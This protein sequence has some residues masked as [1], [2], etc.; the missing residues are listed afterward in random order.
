MIRQF[1]DR[2]R[3]IVITHNKKTMQAADQ[4]YGVTMQERGV[5]TRVKVRFDQVGAHGELPATQADDTAVEARPDRRKRTHASRQRAISAEITPGKDTPESEERVSLKAA[6]AS[7]R[8]QADAPA[9]DPT[10]ATQPTEAAA[11]PNDAD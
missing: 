3:F 5:S 8:E 11:S 10:Q 9:S 7:M 1:T 2:S 6:L 4:L